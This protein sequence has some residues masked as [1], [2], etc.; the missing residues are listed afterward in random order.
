MLHVRRFFRAA[1]PVA[2]AAIMTGCT[3]PSSES[4]NGGAS[5][6]TDHTATAAFFDAPF[7]SD[8][9]L[10][11]DG[12]A[13]LS[14]F[15]NPASNALAKT[16]IDIASITR[17]FG[18][19]TPV[20]FAADREIDTSRLPSVHHSMAPDSPVFIVNVTES[21]A[22]FLRRTPIEARWL[23]DGGP[24]GAPNLLALLPVQGI[25]L[26]LQE[27][28]AAV[29]RK[30]L[31]VPA[32]EA[33]TAMGHFVEGTAPP[34]MNADAFVKHRDALVHLAAAGIPTDDIAAF[35]VFTTGAPISDYE[36]AFTAA[37]SDAPTPLPQTPFVQNEVFADYCVYET[38]ILMPVFQEGT[39]P[40]TSKGGAWKFDTAGKP[41]LQ[42]YEEANFVVTIP[43]IPMPASGYPMVV[44]SRTGA[45]GE[46][47]L[48]DRGVRATPGGPAIEAGTG[49][50]LVFAKAG[51]AGASVD[52]PHGGRRNVTKG[53]EQFLV[54]NIGN[55][56][57][58]RDNIRQSAL[59][60]GLLPPILQQ[61]TIDV[62]DCAGA[63]TA[64][65]K[66][67]FDT[68]T[69]T[70]MGHSMGAS[71][72][73]L[74]A[75]FAPYR[76]IIL[77]GAGGSFLANVVHKQKPL[78][79]KPLAEVLTGIAGSGYSLSEVDPL[80]GL[81]QWA[82]ESADVPP[83][84]RLIRESSTSEPRHVLMMQGIVDHYILPPI[85]NP[86]SLSMGLDLAGE[87]LDEANAELQAYTP[88]GDLLDLVG[89]KQISLPSAGNAGSATAVVVQHA[90]DGIEDGHE[91]VFQTEPPKRQIRC[92]LE[93][94][95]K[96]KP[97]VP[98][99]GA[100][101]EPCE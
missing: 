68:S 52:G 77:S 44:F 57:A 83:Y 67:K 61:I 82:G 35:T 55:P 24:Y 80:L 34:G 32:L 73:P 97:R 37:S 12:T 71:I 13:D 98:P 94:L 15:P 33:S 28:Y 62:S 19:T 46:R 4:P 6:R 48:V 56:I 43:R 63:V 85:A 20:W 59:E 101:L 93:S 18:T 72:V 2:L 99:P 47:P 84:A 31:T 5:I 29:V 36:A 16:I 65:G 45:G 74:A 100:F 89:R 92:F 40:Y 17:G 81:L 42:R 10:L 50:A 69:L 79:T 21:S 41:I 27:R 8:A 54:F 86:M 58:L 39:P 64:D 14:A 87:A 3:G 49:P 51:F 95:A 75:A 70:I 96:G 11:P 23:A 78:A 76:A 66:A 88:I 9:R 1:F 7:P 60:L 22:D 53:D 25:P 38:T 90:E 30:S 91:V 26:R